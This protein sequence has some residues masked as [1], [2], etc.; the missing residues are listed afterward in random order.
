[1][2]TT[3]DPTDRNF[4]TDEM[5]EKGFV[6]I[7]KFLTDEQCY[8]LTQGYNSPNAYRKTVVMER[9]RFQKAARFSALFLPPPLIHFVFHQAGRQSAVHQVGFEARL[10]PYRL[11]RV[12]IR[13]DDP[14]IVSFI[15]LL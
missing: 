8:E 10:Q 7:P 6:V 2:N 15:T 3:I 5:Q 13:A 1:M 12:E 11:Q 9:Y 4:V 14:G